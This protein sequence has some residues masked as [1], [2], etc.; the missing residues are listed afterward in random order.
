MGEDV[1]VGVG[2]VYGVVVGDGGVVVMDWIG[3]I[4]IVVLWIGIVLGGL[5]GGMVVEVVVNVLGVSDKMV[6]VVKVVISGVML[7]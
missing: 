5:L 6:D 3:I 4:K 2:V 7:E 1:D